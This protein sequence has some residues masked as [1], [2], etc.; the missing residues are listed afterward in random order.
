MTSQLP[1]Q[2]RCDCSRGGIVSVVWTRPTDFNSNAYSWEAVQAIVPQ[3]PACA[4]T[5]VPP[6]PAVIGS[7]R[8]DC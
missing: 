1:C 2:V 6:E 5:R 4:T 7:P 8:C 3:K